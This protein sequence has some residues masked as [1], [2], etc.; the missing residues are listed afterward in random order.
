MWKKVSPKW[1]QGRDARAPFYT[2]DEK[3]SDAGSVRRYR[4]EDEEVGG[5]KEGRKWNCLGLV[6]GRK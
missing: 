2:G 5:V 1:C 6:G 3:D 4:I